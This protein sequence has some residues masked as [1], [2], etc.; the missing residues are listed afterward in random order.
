MQSTIK[1]YKILHKNLPPLFPEATK[2]KM[3]DVL[4]KFEKK[5]TSLDDLE[6]AMAEFGYEIW[7]WNKAYREFLE[8][9]EERMGAHF[10]LSKPE[11]AINE[12]LFAIRKELRDFT[13]QEILSTEKSKYLRRVD[14]YRNMVQSV[15]EII[16]NL[17]QMADA[18]SD[19]PALA[20]EIRSK[21]RSFEHSLSEL[22]PALD[23]E[24]VLRS[25]EFFEGRRA[26]LNR[27]RGIHQPVEI[28][29]ED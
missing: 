2:R 10:F 18:E 14:E 24:A 21:V 11:L 25:V 6:E 8:S 20:A 15:Q 17:R 5:P 26:E 22:G 29:F 4:N 16:S 13:D 23:H 27:L 28:S 1:I 7:P 9:S 3:A 19:H 12:A